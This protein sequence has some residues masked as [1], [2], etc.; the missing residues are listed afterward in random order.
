MESTIEQIFSCI[1]GNNND[2]RLKAEEHLESLTRSNT[3][4]VFSTLLHIAGLQKQGVSEVACL[5]IQKKILTIPENIK[6]LQPNDYNDL[7]EKLTALITVNSSLNLLKRISDILG[8]TFKYTNKFYEYFE[9]LNKFKD[10]KERNVKLFVLYS[11]ETFAEYTYEDEILT[12]NSNIFVEFFA[13]YIN[14]PEPEVKFAAASSF[15]NF[16]GFINN[17]EFIKTYDSMFKNFLGLIV[18]GIKHNEDSGLK[19]INSVDSICRNH[20]KFTVNYVDQLLTI[21]TEII[22]TSQLS[23]GI[24]NAAL[25]SILTLSDFNKAQV[26]KSKVFSEKTL[27]TLMR[28]LTEQDDD[29]TE[30]LGS[31]DEIIDLTNSSTEAYVLQNLAQL[32]DTLSAKFLIP[33]LISYIF[34]CINSENWKEKYAGLMTLSMVFEGAK[35]NFKSEFDNFSKLIIPA[36]S[37]SHPKVIYAA[38][39]C[40]GLVSEEFTPKFQ[41]INSAIVVPQI[42]NVMANHTER[43]LRLRAISTMISYIRELLPYDEEKESVTP[44]AEPLISACVNYFEVALQNKLFEDVEESLS[45]ISI[46]AGLLENT[47][48]QYYTQLMPGMKLLL[49]ETPNTTTEQNKLR[50]ILLSTMGYMLGSFKENP[51]AIEGDIVEIIT[52]ISSMQGKIEEDDTQHKSILE[53]YDAMLFALKEKFLPFMEQMIDQIARC[54]NREIKLQAQDSYGAVGPTSNKLDQAIEL[55]FK[56]LGGKK[57]LTLNPCIIE[58]K[59]Q[60]FHL[61]V[62]AFKVLKKDIKPWRHQ[63]FGLLDSHIGFKLSKSVVD[64]CQRSLFHIMNSLDTEE[65]MAEVFHRFSTP[66]LETARVY[67]EVN[68]FEQSHKV[69]KRIN[70][71]FELFHT[72]DLIKEDFIA[73]WIN[74][75]VQ[76]QNVCSKG[77]KEVFEEWGNPKDMDEETLE[78]FTYEYD[79]PNTLMHATMMSCVHMM[80]LFKEKLENI[81]LEKLGGYFFIHAQNYIVED[82]IHYSALFYAE[83]FNYCSDSTF[84]M[85]YKKVMDLIL[86]SARRTE[87]VNY[88]QTASYLFGVKFKDNDR[89]LL[90]EQQESNTSHIFQQ[91][92]C[93]FQDY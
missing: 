76:A 57:I 61:I 87:D 11:L 43:K 18:E 49:Q 53:I 78:D 28:V 33:K 21:Y 83:V 2:A 75:L 1:M 47:F 12:S 86:P 42:V 84:Q 56:M 7:V 90:N 8:M 59:I 45:L 3:I 22:G 91:F 17:T 35:D 5:L 24:R 65:E 23:S 72:P 9:I 93:G 48:G 92:I 38:M 50:T 16:L 80:K 82:E 14:D 27:P 52:L 70:K 88:T 40:V 73:N 37:H 20:P 39:T 10:T 85:G 64:Y 69:L 13:I 44:Y 25:T 34:Q 66:M 63:L 55:D 19:M 67:L 77:K 89:L 15:A 68:N 46:L 29:L 62:N 74:I 54:A 30:W 81:I 60:A 51:G 36:L 26:K 6:K 31:A 79:V 4:E 58:Q 41:T 32:N 71:S